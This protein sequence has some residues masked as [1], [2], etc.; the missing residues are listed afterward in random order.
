VGDQH[1]AFRVRGGDATEP[2]T[3][4]VGLMRR[5]TLAGYSVALLLWM[6]MRL[7]LGRR[8]YLCHDIKKPHPAISFFVPQAASAFRGPPVRIAASRFR[9][10]SDTAGAHGEG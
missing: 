2:R 8:W 6:L 5:F 3:P 1:P 9:L 10:P 7:R 4:G